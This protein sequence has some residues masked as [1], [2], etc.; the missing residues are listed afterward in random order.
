MNVKK[1]VIS[2]A[3]ASSLVIG[4]TALAQNGN[5]T[6]GDQKGRSMGQALGQPGQPRG[7]QMQDGFRNARPDQ[8]PGMMQNR[9]G[10]AE[11]SALVETY[12]GLTVNDLRDALQDDQ[13]LAGLIEANDQS[14]DDFIAEALATLSAN[15]DEAVEAGRLTTEQAA[16]MLAQLEEQ[17][18]AWINGEAGGFGIGVPPSDAIPGF[19][20]GPQQGRLQ[21]V[22]V[23]ALAETYTG[24]TVD[25]LGDALQDD[26]SLAD[27]IEAND[28][29]VDDF[30][31]EAVATVSTNLDEAVEAGRI[32]PEQAADML[33]QYEEQISAWVNGETPGLGIGRL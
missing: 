19:G 1:L 10:G 15:L 30:I 7:G 13:T 25:E 16:D 29:S 18:T 8:A 26:Q 12:T 27:L 17:V 33:S 28:Q 5:P 20:P 3:L 2:T 14:V 4:G 21:G 32:T 6:P 31:A 23:F 11:L 9:F 22:D 24:L